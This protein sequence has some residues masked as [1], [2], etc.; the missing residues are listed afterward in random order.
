MKAWAAGLVGSVTALKYAQ[1][2]LPNLDQIVAMAR[3]RTAAVQAGG[4]NGIYPKRLAESFQTVYCFEP[5]ADC[6]AAM[7]INAPESNI[8]R[9]QAALGCERRLVGLSQQ[10]RDGK[11]DNH[12]GITH[13]AGSG[14]VPTLQVDDLGLPVC[15]LV[16]LDVEGWELYALQGAAQTLA[17]CRPVVSV[18]INKSL[19][20]VGL[21]REDVRAYL[22]SHDYRFVVKLASDEVF[23]PA[24]WGRQ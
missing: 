24:E 1:R 23:V 14:T 21:E 15:D 12:E 2:D 3:G 7:Q 10:R 17:R 20:F 19:G 4:N 8:I 13:V 6:F 22:R 16:A 9:I 5:S 11:S 18:E